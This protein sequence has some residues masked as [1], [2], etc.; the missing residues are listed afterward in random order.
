LQI[1]RPENGISRLAK[2]SEE[3][4]TESKGM[5]DPPQVF[6]NLISHD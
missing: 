3:Q 6:R 4:L 1:N 5:I 2:P